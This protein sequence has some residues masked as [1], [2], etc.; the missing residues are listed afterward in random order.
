MFEKYVQ[1]EDRVDAEKLIYKKV[2]S[3]IDE[4][5]NDIENTSKLDKYLDMELDGV[6]TNLRTEIPK[7]N[8]RYYMLFGYLALGFN[9]SIISH[10][11][12]CSE[13]AVRIIKNR[14]KSTIKT[15]EA[16]HKL[17]FLQIIG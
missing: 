6:M 4:L 7:L 12:G 17:E 10:F 16:E 2:V 11:M 13:N 1:S 14:L 9:N 15:S 3:L 5:R 8:K